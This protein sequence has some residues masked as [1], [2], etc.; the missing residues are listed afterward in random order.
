MSQAEALG[1]WISDDKTQK[2]EVWLELLQ[3]QKFQ[4]DFSLT[5]SLLLLQRNVSDHLLGHEGRE[6]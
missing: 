2:K 3:Q 4:T 1:N 6:H 5:M